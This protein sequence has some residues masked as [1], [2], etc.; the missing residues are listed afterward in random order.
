MRAFAI[1][2]GPEPETGLALVFAGAIAVDDEGAWHLEWL[3]GGD[4][5]SAVARAHVYEMIAAAQATSWEAA[6]DAWAAKANGLTWDLAEVDPA[7][8]LPDGLPASASKL[9][10]AV[11]ALVDDALSAR[12]ST[13]PAAA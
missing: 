2:A 3:P 12:P 8:C 7:G 10:A 4:P 5:R 13:L 9:H 11:F 1:H 6:L